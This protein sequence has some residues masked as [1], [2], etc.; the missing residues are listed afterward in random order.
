MTSTSRSGKSRLRQGV[1]RGLQLTVPKRCLLVRGDVKS[2]TV[3]L[4]FDDG[5]DP[6]T[7]P[8]ILDVLR[9][10]GVQATFFVIGRQVA[11]HA[12]VVRRMVA[13][14]HAVGGH[15]YLHRAPR[16]VSGWQLMDELRQTDALLQPILDGRSRLFRPPFGKLTASKLWRLWADRRTIVLWNRDPKDFAASSPEQ[17]EAWFREQPLAGGDIVLLH[18][19]SVVTADVLDHVVRDALQAG[20]SFAP[21][22]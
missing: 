7:T 22:G 9:R 10:H 2:S 5:P 16:Q 6:E 4:T 13:E 18:D 11:A 14:G 12:H 17:L 15:T 21:L 1:L 8:R 19:T 3:H 20:L